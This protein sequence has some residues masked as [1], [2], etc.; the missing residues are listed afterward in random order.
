MSNLNDLIC[1]SQRYGRDPRFCIAAGGN[2]SVKDDASLWVKA[3]GVAMGTVDEAGFV[4]LDLAA[5]RATLTQALPVDVE[6]REATF[7]A[8][9]LAARRNAEAGL[10]PSVE[11]AVHAAFPHRFVVHT[12]ATAVNQ[13]SCAG[14]GAKLARDLWGK[15]VVWVDYVDPGVT[16]ART[17]ATHV[18]KADPAQVLA[19]VWQNHGLIVAGPTLESIEAE[20]ER[21]VAAV[22]ARVPAPD[23]ASEGD[24][25]LARR[26][27]PALRGALAAAGAPG[28]VRSVVGGSCL[29]LANDA[30][31]PEWSSAGPLNPDQIVYAGSFPLWLNRAA[32]ADEAALAQHVRARV[33]DY[34]QSYGVLPRIVWCPGVGAFAIAPTAPE[35]TVIAA[36]AEDV[37]RISLG[38]AELS[39]PRSLDG[40]QRGFIESWEVESYRRAMSVAG[41]AGRFA[42]RIA[43]VTGA[44]QGFGRGIAETLIA[45]GAH[46]ALLDRNAAVND[47]TATELGDRALAVTTDVADPDSVVGAVDAIVD[48]WGGADLVISNAGILRA[49]SVTEQ[50]PAEFEAVTRV[51]YLGYFHVVRAV[52]PVL[53]QQY[54]TNPAAW[55]DIIQI[56]SKS[57]LQGSNR[58]AAYAG[59]KFGGI[60][61][62]QSFALEL[63]EHGIKVNAICPG[64]FFDG[65]L[66]SDPERG[67][68]VQYLQTGKVPGAQTIDDVRGFYESKVPMQRGCRVADVMAAIRYIVEQ[69]YETGQ[70]LPVT[71]GQVMLN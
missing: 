61:L 21:L 52:T 18:A 22:R 57:G 31:A 51:N 15:S 56:N 34:Q 70:A 55:T 37:A 2:T 23:N 16:L 20:T 25:V 67:L 60:G 47:A 71:G 3:S 38:A 43:L 11:C 49:G 32:G 7:K 19:M 42:G 17:I 53:A 45:E 65:P 8:A 39:G 14:D 59:G 30:R 28:I 46:V 69:Q 10:R 35:A 41:N 64:N 44:A 13:V 4:E 62:T 66:W 27:A 58:N 33:A 5:L 9:I 54:R 6:A 50:D 1:L 68:F 29:S 12:H 40:A 63:V 48:A 36:M 24:H 26:I